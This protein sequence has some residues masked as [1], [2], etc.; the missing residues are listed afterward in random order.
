MQCNATCNSA[1]GWLCLTRRQCVIWVGTPKACGL[2]SGLQLFPSHPC[3]PWPFSHLCR[4]LTLI[5]APAFSWAWIILTSLQ[6]H[7]EHRL[8]GMTCD[9]EL[10]S[11]ECGQD[12][13]HHFEGASP[14]QCFWEFLHPR[15]GY[16]CHHALRFESQVS[17]P[18]TKRL[19]QGKPNPVL[20]TGFQMLGEEFELKIPRDRAW[21][22]SLQRSWPGAHSHPSCSQVA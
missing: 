5:Q 7:E 6:P 11:P 8:P 4:P 15:H 18:R 1:C 17:T 9:S 3:L 13:N 20:P 19:T 14:S 21:A 10:V 2:P 22:E 16:L 12:P